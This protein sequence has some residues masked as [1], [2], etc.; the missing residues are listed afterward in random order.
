MFLDMKKGLFSHKKEVNKNFF[1][2]HFV[3]FFTLQFG[4]KIVL[5]DGTLFYSSL[6]R[7]PIKFDDRKLLLPIYNNYNKSREGENYN[8]NN[9]KLSWTLW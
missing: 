3:L 5:K 7:L 6:V 9:I 4:E 2:R 8:D 1:I